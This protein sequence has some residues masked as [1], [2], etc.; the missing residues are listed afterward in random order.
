MFWRT[1]DSKASKAPASL[2][3]RSWSITRRLTLLYALSAFVMLAL[4][5]GV[6]Y[7]VLVADLDEANRQL[8]SNRIDILRDILQEQPDDQE[9]LTEE[10]RYGGAYYTRI[11]DED[12]HILLETNGMGELLPPSLFPVPA[13]ISE[14]ADITLK[15][16]LPD[17]R[18]YL[19]ISV[20]ATVNSSSERGRLLQIALDV[21]SEERLTAGYRRWLALVLFWGLLFSAGSGV[22][23]A[24][25]GMRPLREIT[26]AAERITAAQLHERINPAK[27]PKEL[28]VLA[29]AFDRMLNRLQEAFTR[30]SQFSAD[31]AHE[32]RTPINNLMGEAE[33][34]LSR[35]RTPDEYREVLAS[36]L[37]EFARLTRMID[38][39]LFLAH[40][41][42][43]EKVI[44]PSQLDAHKEIEAVIEFHD[45]FA[46]EQ[47]V[48]VACQGEAS[49]KADPM[50]FRRVISNLLSNALQ[51]TPR[52]G[53]VM[54]SVQQIDHQGA[55]IRVADT[56][57]GIAPE[58]LP[59]IFERFYRA[60][61]ARSKSPQGIGLGL[62]I[63][64]S[65]MDL[66]GG[67]VTIASELSQGTTVTLRF[68]SQI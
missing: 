22:A 61:R 13:E 60:D 64:K 26:E 41:E 42:S 39:L 18:S 58:H 57:C 48:E 56:G 24:R 3:D 32:L 68:P 23:I 17:G 40:A 27:W 33:V 38:G 19:L 53:K 45:A 7:W 49:L 29:T 62:A 65:I 15:R 66:H 37:E 12:Q 10:V 16:T 5:A 30:L 63:V 52:G 35:V 14:M 54:I 34:A 11:F 21:T 47:G 50:L 36:S 4:G 51:Y 25:Q 20:W 1:D 46:K 2:P 44:E 55:E 6:L 59:K 9:M 8:L 28:T 67:S 31:L 43:A